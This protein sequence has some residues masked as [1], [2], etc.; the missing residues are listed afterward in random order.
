MKEPQARDKKAEKA[1]DRLLGSLLQLNGNSHNR[2]KELKNWII[3]FF[4]LEKTL[5][6]FKSNKKS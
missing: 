4:I 6:T 1:S 2:I 3:K 5:Q